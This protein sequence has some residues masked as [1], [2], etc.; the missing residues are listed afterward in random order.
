VMYGGPPA[1]EHSIAGAGSEELILQRQALHAWRITF[2]HPITEKDMEV[3]A[4]F[5]KDFRQ[6]MH[7]LRRT[8]SV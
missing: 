3:E 5:P 8:R 1:S 6:L 2:R 7:L 4:P